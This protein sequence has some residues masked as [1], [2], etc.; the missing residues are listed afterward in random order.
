M[1]FLTDNNVLVRRHVTLPTLMCV[2][3][4]AEKKIPTEEDTIKS[5]IDSFGDDIGKT[6]NW[7]TSMFDVRA[8]FEPDS[9]EY[10]ILSYRIQSGQLFQQNAIDKSKGIISKPMPKE[11]HDRH[12]VN[13]IEDPVKRKLYLKIVADKKPYFMRIIY[14]ALMKQYNTYITNTNK[15]ALREFGKTV[16]ELLAMPEDEL[17]ERQADFLRYYNSRLPVSNNDCV[18][19]KICRR[20]EQEFD[21]YLS[22]HNTSADF[23]YTIMK[24]DA[25]YS[26]S[27]YTSISKLYTAYCAR[28]KSYMV[29]VRYERVDE[30]E[31]MVSLADMKAEFERECVSV[32]PNLETL[33]N[34][35]LDLCYRKST[36]K[37]F[38]WDIC[39]EVIIK[40]L[41]ARYNNTLTYPE[42]ATDG[43]ITYCGE[44]FTIKT[45]QIGEIE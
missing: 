39:G 35:V 23:D 38:A 44:R 21:S 7:I 32:C 5:N 26:K 40:N 31:M 18:M 43:E 37:S 17:T 19:N 24:S 6:T 15:N 33:C 10:Q 20:F 11:W 3:R 14:P 36:T 45:K 41:L 28:L 29:F 9:E 25:E 1:V 30:D 34:I 22:K 42:L 12:S 8:K 13:Q 2:Q 4:K 27:Q 16:D